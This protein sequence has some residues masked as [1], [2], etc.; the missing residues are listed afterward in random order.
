LAAGARG[1]NEGATRTHFADP[2]TIAPMKIAGFGFV[3]LV[4]GSAILSGANP[5]VNASE[6]TVGLI[7]VIAGIAGLGGG[8]WW[9]VNSRT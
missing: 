8:L 6:W 1:V 3:G 7:L 9:M 4:L 2:T 5:D